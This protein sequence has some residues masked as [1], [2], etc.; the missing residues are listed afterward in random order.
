MC[1]N[2]KYRIYGKEFELID[3]KE[4][5]NINNLVAYRSKAI[6]LTGPGCQIGHDAYGFNSADMKNIFHCF[7]NE[8]W[9]VTKFNS[10]SHDIVRKYKC[11]EC[12]SFS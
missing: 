2:Y 10:R 9:D 8:F 1:R 12:I 4:I 7:E 11:C 5:E 6:G 3:E